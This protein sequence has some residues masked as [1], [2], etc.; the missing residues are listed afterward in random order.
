MFRI[1][2]SVI[3][4]GSNGNSTLIESK[5]TSLLFDAGKSGREIESRLNSLGK[6]P[7]NI[8]AILVSHEHRD[9]ISGVGILSRRYNIPVYI[10]KGTYANSRFVLGRLFERKTFDI[11]KKFKIKDLKI[12][13]I[14]TSHDAASPCGFMIQES[15]KAFGIITDTGYITPQVKDAVKHLNGIL[16]ESNH[17]IDMLING[18]YPHFLKNRILNDDGHLSNVVAAELI[19]KE[20]SDKLKLVV[21]GHLSGNNN[22]PELAQKTFEVIAKN[23]LKQLQYCT[24][25]RDKV[26]GKFII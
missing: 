5:K 16:L 1:E 22:T 24:A 3:A 26:T 11:N 14:K 2:I 8:D 19:K 4:S 10:A 7:E 9:H 15:S 20:A 21:L 12:K 17:D 13:P 6:S 23:K 18:P 25:S